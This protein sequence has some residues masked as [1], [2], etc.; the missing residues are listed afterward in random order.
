M[1]NY[2][3][4]VKSQLGTSYDTLDLYD[5]VNIPVIFNVK[6]VREPQS[7]KTNYTKQFDIPTSHINN[8]FF[9]GIRESGF[10]VYE[11]NPNH[12]VECQLMYD[13]NVIIDGYLQVI[14]VNKTDED[15]Y[16]SIVIYGELSSIFNELVGC[17]IS[18]YDIL[19]LTINTLKKILK[20]VGIH[21]YKEMV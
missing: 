20:I 9:E 17:K 19:N 4:T 2:K 13:D 1:R 5:N 21:L 18:D 10:S 8:I 11:F 3:L 16:Y 7:I 6:D 12:K 14:D 15:G